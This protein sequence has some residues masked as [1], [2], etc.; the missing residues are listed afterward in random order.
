M[1]LLIRCDASP[2]LGAG[3]A[4]RCMA[5]A[6]YAEAAM[7]VM[8]SG[9][10]LVASR[11]FSTQAIDAGPNLTQSVASAWRPDWIVVDVDAAE[12][13]VV[14]ASPIA[15]VLRLDDGGFVD[16]TA[17]KLVLNPN[18]GVT[19]ADYP[20]VAPDR[21]LLGPSYALLRRPFA[22]NR[23]RY[24]GG[25]SVDGKPCVFVGFGGSDPPN[26]TARAVRA[27][28]AL[29]GCRL[30]VVL[31]V[32]NPHRAAVEAAAAGDP[33]VEIHI[34]PPD[35]AVL[36]ARSD[37]A[38]TAASGML[39]EFMSLGVPI[40]AIAIAENQR[41]NLEWLGANGGG[42]LGW[43]ADVADASLLAATRKALADR[44]WRRAAAEKGS[45]LVDGR[46]VERVLARM[47]SMKEVEGTA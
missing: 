31:G 29:D 37:V 28:A 12:G 22:D 40:L 15:P 20:R 42:A 36:M 11:G 10:E 46:G 13:V 17:A 26:M 39:W 2:Q 23:S 6:E 3:H 32:D 45:K 14:R 35:L 25:V 9:H 4:M 16:P 8:R 38:V 19:D 1:R 41:R 21:L 27:L 44:E 24:A 43:H 18:V 7:F 34:D 30:Q 33:N 47:A 5:L